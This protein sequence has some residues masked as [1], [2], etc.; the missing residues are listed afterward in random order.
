MKF[1]QL[2]IN[3]ITTFN[4]QLN[5][6]LISLL[7]ELLYNSLYL[8]VRN[9]MG[10][11][12]FTKLILELDLWFCLSTFASLWGLIVKNVKKMMQRINDIAS[13]INSIHIHYRVVNSY[14]EFLI[15][16]AQ[17]ACSE[18]QM[19]TRTNKNLFPFRFNFC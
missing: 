19:Y 4:H 6:N 13:I 2:I 1:G 15:N 3:L 17:G 5:L 9:V 11:M 10:E 18:A 8:S 16:R 14:K 7:A 12:R